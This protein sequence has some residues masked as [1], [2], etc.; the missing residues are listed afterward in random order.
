[1]TEEIQENQQIDNVVF[2]R[3]F[4]EAIK[5]FN[6]SEQLKIYD[7]IFNF[8]FNGKEAELEG[9]PKAIFKIVKPLLLSNLKKRKM[10]KKGGRPGRPPKEKEN[11]FAQESSEVDNFVEDYR[12][13]KNAD[14]EPT[15]EEREQIADTLSD[16]GEYN[17]EYWKKIFTKAKGGYKIDGIN[18][19]CTLKKILTDH[20]AIF[21]NEANLQPN[22]EAQKAAAD[23]QAEANKQA[24][25]EY[26]KVVEEEANKRESERL[27]VNSAQAAADYLNKYIKGGLQIKQIATDY[28]DFKAIYNIKI[29]SGG[30]YYVPETS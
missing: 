6:E 9:M 13:N 8:A 2:Y 14:F 29:N 16:L 17:S 25:A 19:A 24:E 7:S 5:E 20:N 21:R 12:Q 30:K 28:K 26:D 10:A 4:Y 27:S 22:K 23:K 18:I 11:I 3:S 15:S 1:M